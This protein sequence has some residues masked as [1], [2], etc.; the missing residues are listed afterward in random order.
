ML[1]RRIATWVAGLGLATLAT[2]TLSG[3]VLVPAPIHPRVVRP[4]PVIV[5]PGAPVYHRHRDWDRAGRRSRWD[6]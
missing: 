5:V 6:R 4:R 2:I 3:C 1:R